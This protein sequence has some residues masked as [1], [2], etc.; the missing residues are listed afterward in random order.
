MQKMPVLFIGHGSPMNAIEDN[1]YT[2]MW[3]DIANKIPK[4]SAILSISAH[5]VTDGSRVTDDPQPKVVYDM[6]GFP[7]ELYEVDYH[8]LGA[9][10]LAHVT[11]KLINGNIHFDS[12]WGIDHGT[13]SVL[14]VMYPEAD[15]PVFQLSLDNKATAAEHF[16]IGT[17]LKKLREQGV[18]ILGSGNVVHNLSKLGWEMEDGYDWGIDFDRYIKDEVVKRDYRN[19]IDYKKAGKSAEMAFYTSEH[20]DPL[21]YV[22]GAS[23][24]SDTLSIYNNACTLGSLSMTCYLFE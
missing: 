16:A 2:R 21:L 1:V 18:L 17:K 4:P 14:N 20:F 3:C 7:K 15:I 9:P 19:V 22:L 6:Y 12:S 5:W 8:P 10:E 13:W 24:E 23:D 11:K